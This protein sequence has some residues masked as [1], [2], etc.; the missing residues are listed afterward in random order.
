MVNNFIITT[1]GFGGLPRCK[2][3]VTQLSL[4]GKRTLKQMELKYPT[5]EKINE[6]NNRKRVIRKSRYLGVKFFFVHFKN[7]GK[8]YKYS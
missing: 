6:R 3:A 4:Q 2:F 1:W 5:W 8:T 7:L